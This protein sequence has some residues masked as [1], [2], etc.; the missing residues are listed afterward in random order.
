MTK[1]QKVALV[2]GSAKGLGKHLALFLAKNDFAVI[3]H[4]RK[5]R[6]LAEGLLRNLQKI[7]ANSS[8]VA[9]DVTDAGDVEKIFRQIEKKY[10]RVDLLV[11]N[12]GNFIYKDFSKTTFEEFTDIFESNVYS[13]Y[14][15]SLRVLKLM[16]KQKN[17]HIINI[18]VVGADSLTVREKSTPY[19]IAKNALYFLTKAIA[20]EEAKF[21]I[22]VNMISPA[23]LKTD[24]FSSSDFPMGRSAKYED[25]ANVLLFLLSRNAYYINGANIE[26][27]GGFIPGLDLS[28]KE[29]KSEK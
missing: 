19:F 28:T 9:G 7:S 24:I 12:V 21:G 27:A 26:V 16:R 2:T 15:C 18:G 29:K 22:H 11:N 8:I 5:S 10:A 23:S 14:L 1:M 13:A 6:K 17:G 25:V 4:Y 3:V 20:H